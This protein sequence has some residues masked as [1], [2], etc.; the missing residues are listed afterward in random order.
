MLKAK[1]EDDSEGETS[2]RRRTAISV[3]CVLAAGT[4]WGIIGIFVRGMSALGLNSMQI[5]AVRIITTAALLLIGILIFKPSLLRVKP[6]HLWCFVGTGLISIVVFSYC[7]FSTIEQTSLSAAAVLLY[8]AP[9]FVTLMSAVIFGEKL[10]AQKLIAC[11]V[12]FA[13]CVLVTGILGSGESVPPR[14][15]ITG[16][17]SAVGYALYSIFGRFALNYGYNSITITA[18]TFFFACAGVLP[19]ADLRGLWSI[20]TTGSGA[21]VAHNMLFALALGVVTALLPYILYTLGLS[22]IESGRAS[23]IASVEPVVATLTGILVFGEP[24]TLTGG[25]GILLVVAAIALM[26][27]KNRRAKS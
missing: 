2:P 1:K 3:A 13:G 24:M 4:L 12:A 20:L 9:V 22:G 8:T 26:N 17:I 25:L 15:L 5:V 27:L 11:A 10:T 21:E 19:L 18:Y 14:A 16:L 6:R 23:V 7:Y